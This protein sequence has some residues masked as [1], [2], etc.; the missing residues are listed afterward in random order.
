MGTLLSE[1]CD[2]S[3]S[4]KDKS[5]SKSFALGP[6]VG[7]DPQR[8]NFTSGIPTC[9]Y[10]K[11]LK[12]ALPQTRKETLRYP[13]CEPMECRLHWVPNAK[14]SRWP[15]TFHVVC[16]HFIHVGLPTRTQFPVEYGLKKY[17]AFLFESRC[18]YAPFRVVYQPNKED[19]HS[20]IL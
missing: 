17:Q 1:Q 16:A 13:Q 11:T 19:L 7:L 9:W 15:C 3:I 10:L 18:G 2:N 5:K 6:G 8:H 12:F 20:V 14:F 4:L